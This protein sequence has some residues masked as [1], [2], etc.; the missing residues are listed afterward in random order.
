M[1][2]KSVGSI[3]LEANYDTI[4]QTLCFLPVNIML[5][6]VSNI[7]VSMLS[8]VIDKHTWWL[9]ILS[10]Q[11]C[12]HWLIAYSLTSNWR[13]FQLHAD[14]AIFPK[15]AVRSPLCPALTGSWEAEKR[16]FLSRYTWWDKEPRIFFRISM[17]ICNNLIQTT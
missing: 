11:W 7:F 2:I 17:T 9:P 15:T 14:V 10:Y 6:S 16:I 4:H 1:P 13:I 3:S 12:S 5:F 8:Y